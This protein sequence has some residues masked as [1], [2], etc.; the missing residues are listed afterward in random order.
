MWCN[1]DLGLSQAA[2]LTEYT[3]PL[4][5]VAIDEFHNEEAIRT[6]SLFPHLFKIISPIDFPHLKDLLIDHLNQPFIDAVVHRFTVGF[7][8][9]THT[10]YSIYPLTVDNSGQPPN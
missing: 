4:P 7:C 3:E 1:L 2:L 8:P 9:F 10:R 5:S 6:I